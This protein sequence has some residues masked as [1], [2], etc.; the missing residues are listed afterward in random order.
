MQ[1]ACWNGTGFLICITCFPT[2]TF[3]FSLQSTSFNPWAFFRVGKAGSGE[4]RDGKKRGGGKPFE[5]GLGSCQIS[6]CLIHK[7]MH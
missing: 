3:V 1:Q 2:E 7:I 6:T 4:K 5:G